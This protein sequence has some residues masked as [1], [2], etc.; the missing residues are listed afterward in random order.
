MDQSSNISRSFSFLN[1][2]I[3]RTKSTPPANWKASFPIKCLLVFFILFSFGLS[4]IVIALVITFASLYKPTYQIE[5]TTIGATVPNAASCGKQEILPYVPFQRIY[6]GIEAVPNSWPWVVFYIETPP[7]SSSNCTSS[8]CGGTLIHP[9]YV[10][11]AAHCITATNGSFIRIIAGL[12][13]T[14]ST[15]ERNVR[16]TRRVEKVF[17]H[18][19]FVQLSLLGDIAILQL[20]APFYLNRFIQLA[21]LSDQQPLGN[22]TVIIAGWGSAEFRGRYA[23]VLKQAF[24]QVIAGCNQWWSAEGVDERRQICVANNI[25]GVSACSG[26]SGGPILSRD[27]QNRWIVSGIASYVERFNCKTNNSRP[28]VYTRVAYYLPWIHQ[29]AYSNKSLD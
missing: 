13:N 11:T 8:I 24:T 9:R 21:C 15:L 20:N 7:C 16:Q 18:P 12:H 10:L 23:P 29:I 6:G 25:T 17:I 19:T 14:S 1:N 5:T 2:Q 4:I 3:Q 22:D 26:D 28:N 27:A